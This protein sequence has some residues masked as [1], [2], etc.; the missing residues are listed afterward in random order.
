MINDLTTVQSV[1]DNPNLAQGFSFDNLW[2]L[3]E[4]LADH[5]TVIPFKPP[6]NEFIYCEASPIVGVHMAFQNCSLSYH[7]SILASCL[8]VVLLFAL[9]PR[10]GKAT[11]QSNAEIVD[12]IYPQPTIWD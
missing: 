1:Q 7:T 10:Y 11:R 4:A 8:S 3:G 12:S 2:C 6:F 9:Q 5:N